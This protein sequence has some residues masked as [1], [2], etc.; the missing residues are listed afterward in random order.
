MLRVK[1]FPKSS[2]PNSAKCW[3]DNRIHPQLGRMHCDWKR[4]CGTKY[5]GALSKPKWWCF[6][7]CRPYVCNVFPHFREQIPF[8]LNT[9]LGRST[10]FGK[11]SGSVLPRS[12][13]YCEWTS[14]TWY[15]IIINPSSSRFLP[16][17]DIPFTPNTFFSRWT[18]FSRI[19]WQCFNGMSFLLW[20]ND[21][22]VA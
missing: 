13:S 7:T 8:T 5:Q 10:N 22:Y 14:H 20:V 17:F 11:A 2:C 18:N 1:Y 6:V 4:A 19:L 21:L 3:V 12:R 16:V 9:S 15:H